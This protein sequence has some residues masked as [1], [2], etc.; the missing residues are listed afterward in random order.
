M[1]LEWPSLVETAS[2]L[3]LM[4]VDIPLM[5]VD[6]SLMQVDASFNALLVSYATVI[7]LPH[8]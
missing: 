3:N 8:Q 4:Q 2:C 1:Q 6:I 5:Q 7:H